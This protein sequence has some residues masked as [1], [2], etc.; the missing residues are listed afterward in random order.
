M[1]IWI[2]HKRR[3]KH[4]REIKKLKHVESTRIL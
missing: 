3:V 4:M 1:I 2:M